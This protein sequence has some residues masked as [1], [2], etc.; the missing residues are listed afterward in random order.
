MKGHPGAEDCQ[1]YDYRALE[2]GPEKT[3]LSGK[4]KNQSACVVAAGPSYGR[5]LLTPR[6]SFAENDQA[7]KGF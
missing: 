3:S 1:V 6:M 2:G 7:H 5:R 4:D